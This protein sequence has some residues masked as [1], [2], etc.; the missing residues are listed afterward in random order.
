VIKEYFNDLSIRKLGFISSNIAGFIILLFAILVINQE[1]K[2]YAHQ[3]ELIEKDFNQSTKE[4][5]KILNQKK[6]EYKTKVMRY[7]IGI[8]GVGLFMFFAIYMLLRVVSHMIDNELKEFLN[9]LFIASKQHKTI[10]KANF[11]FEES[12]SLI[13]NANVLI[14]DIL[15]NEKKLQVLNKSLE[16]KV[17]DK[18]KK[19]QMLV[20]NQDEFIKKSIHEIN[21]PLSIILTNIDLLKMNQ[22]ENKN[23]TNI[24]SASKIIHN[25][26]NDLS[27]LLKKDRVEYKK[28]F[29]NFSSFLKN[30][31]QF[32][33]EVA[34]SNDLVFI[35]NIQNNIVINFNEVY[36]QRIVDNNLSNAIKYSFSGGA[37]YVKLIKE[38][39]F[40]KFSVKTNSEKIND[41]SKIFDDYYREN[42]VK[43]GFGIGL[44]IVKEICDKNNITVEIISNDE[45]T[46]FIYRFMN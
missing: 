40:I 43:G 28:D 34:N 17:E 33:N 18:T 45:F 21:T 16:K 23:I 32:F 13:D 42:S 44:N 4:K 35:A 24:E 26:F 8:G 20:A 14:I 9:Q 7:V 15:R 3:I 19:L 6:R 27:F 46:K 39:D 31:L 10:K 29:I 41:I 36:L 5:Q 12:K 22:I 11:N 37:I 1:Y 2:Y 30:R 38:K 25:I